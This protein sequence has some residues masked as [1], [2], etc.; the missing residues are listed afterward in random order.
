MRNSGTLSITQGT[1]E[2][3]QPED[4]LFLKERLV[5]RLASLRREYCNYDRTPRENDVI[6]FAGNDQ[7]TFEG[8]IGTVFSPELYIPGLGARFVDPQFYADRI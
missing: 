7:T 6:N 3:G 5:S 8:V 1:L 2:V 4:V